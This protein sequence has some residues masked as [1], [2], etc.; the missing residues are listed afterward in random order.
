[1]A[2][3]SSRN[4]PEIVSALPHEVLLSPHPEAKRAACFAQRRASQGN[5]GDYRGLTMLGMV[6][7]CRPLLAALALLTAAIAASISPASARSY[8]R[9]A[10]HAQGY[11]GHQA[12]WHQ[13]QYHSRY[14]YRQIARQS[15]RPRDAAPMPAPDYAFVTPGVDGTTRIAR[16]QSRHALRR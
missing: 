14:R 4:D 13:P 15:R 6:A 2:T 3:K 5:G 1:I 11:A 16:Y 8:H 12:R 7:F 10:H 9:S